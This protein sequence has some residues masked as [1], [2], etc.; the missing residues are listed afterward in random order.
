MK[1][2]IIHA[3]LSE[4]QELHQRLIDN[5]GGTPGMADPTMLE[6]LVFLPHSGHEDKQIRH[7]NFETIFEQAAALMQGFCTSQCFKD[8]NR[9]IGVY[10]C[11][12]FLKMN[13]LTMKVSNQDLVKF[14]LEQIVPKKLDNKAIAKWLEQNLV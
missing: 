12:V 13:G 8:A 10:T 4:V 6:A 2:A 7:L 9:S 5:I 3:T 11:L 1:G 14:I